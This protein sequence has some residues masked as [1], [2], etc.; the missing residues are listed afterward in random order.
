MHFDMFY[1]I[2]YIFLKHWLRLTK[3][4]SQPTHENT[5]LHNLQDT[6]SKGEKKKVCPQEEGTMGLDSLGVW[7]VV[8]LF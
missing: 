3:F 1:F 2:L 5:E 4:I 8:W 7:H 6:E